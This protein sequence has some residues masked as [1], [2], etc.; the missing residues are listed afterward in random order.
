MVWY[1]WETIY[2]IRASMYLVR[3]YDSIYAGIKNT[4]PYI[5]TSCSYQTQTDILHTCLVW[6]DHRLH[7]ARQYHHRVWQLRILR[8]WR[9]WPVALVLSYT[10]LHYTDLISKAYAIAELIDNSLTATRE[11]AKRQITVRWVCRWITRYKMEYFIFHCL[12]LVNTFFFN[13]FYLP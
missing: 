8:E 9:P 12:S 4:M 10:A 6:D 13:F 3:K 2:L 11:C 5:M 1:D 7:A